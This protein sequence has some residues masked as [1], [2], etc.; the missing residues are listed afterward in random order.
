VLERDGRRLGVIGLTD[1][2]KQYAATLDKPGVAY[3]D[4]SRGLPLWLRE[5]LASIEPDAVLVSPH[6]G[7][8]MV[9][10]P[11]PRIRH[12]AAELIEAGA[13]LVAGHSAH[14]FQ[15][16][17]RRVVYD[18]GDFVDDY[19]TD[20]MLRND[21]GL[22]FLVTFDDQGPARLEALPLKLEYSHTRLADGEDAAW[23]KRRF[24]DACSRLGTDA[25]EDD[26]RL[27]VTWKPET[28]G[29]GSP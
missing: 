1:H 29:R 17:G 24:R 11:L 15:G 9:A 21:L 16:V 6:W 7:P 5:T 13:T 2:P 23:I 25:H 26:G 18:L 10:E 27:V 12:A 19:A 22:L 20:P 14:V 4:L 28:I 8:N 3:A